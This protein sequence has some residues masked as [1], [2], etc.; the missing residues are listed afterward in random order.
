[1]ASSEVASPTKPGKQPPWESPSA[2]ELTFGSAAPF[3]VDGT[4]QQLGAFPRHE[5]VVGTIEP[6]AT[7]FELASADATLVLDFDAM[8]RSAGTT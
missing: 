8:T 4:E 3:T 6:Y 1:M 7:G 2:G 5:S